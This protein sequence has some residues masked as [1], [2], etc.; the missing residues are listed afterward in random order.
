MQFNRVTWY[1]KLFALTLFTALPFVGFYFGYKYGQATFTPKET[2]VYQ[3]VSSEGKVLKE[4]KNEELKT[5][6]FYEKGKLKY[7]GTVVTPETCWDVETE[8]IIRESFPEQITINLTTKKVGQICG[9]ALTE[10]PFS[11]EIQ[12]SEAASISVQLNGKVIE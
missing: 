2:I 7:S 10:I 5:T 11:G 9:Q 12:A 1:S 8:A 3:P 4:I 6:V